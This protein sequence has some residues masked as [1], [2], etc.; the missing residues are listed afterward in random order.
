MNKTSRKCFIMGNL[1][2]HQ[3]VVSNPW[4]NAAIG[5]LGMVIPLVSPF[6]PY[7]KK[8]KM[9]KKGSHPLYE[10]VS[11]IKEKEKFKQKINLETVI[12]IT[13]KLRVFERSESNSN[14]LPVVISSP[15]CRHNNAEL[16]PKPGTRNLILVSHS[17]GR[18]PTA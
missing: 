3:V 6:P 12:L 7:R 10:T 18:N 11:L 15:R 9:C 14:R 8:R 13:H 17:G 16:E 2:Q 4:G 1:G 5:K